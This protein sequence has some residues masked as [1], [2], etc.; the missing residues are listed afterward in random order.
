MTYRI[1]YTICCVLALG[2]AVNAVNL[3]HTSIIAEA[4]GNHESR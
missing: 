1:F 2:I 3:V 4:F